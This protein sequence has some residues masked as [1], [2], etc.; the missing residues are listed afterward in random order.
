MVMLQH[1]QQDKGYLMAERPI[2]PSRAPSTFECVDV[3]AEGIQDGTFVGSG[4]FVPV[5]AHYGMVQQGM[6]F[7]KFF[8][9]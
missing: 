4:Y 9:I 2:H 5:E 6:Y 1:A 7:Q 8:D 3:A